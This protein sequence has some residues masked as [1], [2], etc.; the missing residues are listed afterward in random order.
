MKVLHYV[1]VYAPAWQFGGP[2]LSVSQLCEGLV[3][4]GH[5]VEIFTSN[6]GLEN[7]PEIIPNCPTVNNGVTVTY[8]SNVGGIGG[9]NSPQM[10][11]SV[12]ERVKEFD[13]VHITGIWQPTSYAACHAAKS[14]DIPYILSLRGAL[15]PYSWSQKT[16]KKAL[17]Y[18]WREHWN[19]NNA[20]AI[21]YTAQ[22]EFEECRWLNLPGKPIISPN[23]L[24]T[25]FWQPNPSGAKQWRREQGFKEDE[26]LLLNIGRLHHK[27]GLDLLPHVL[28]RIRDLEW[29]MIFVGGDD[30][31]T[32]DKLVGEFKYLNLLDRVRFL[33]KCE[34]KELCT[35]YSACNLFVLPSRHENFGNVVIE[36]LACGC[37]VMISDKVGVHR[38]IHQAGMGWVLK[39]NITNW[40]DQLRELIIND[41]F[42]KPVIVNSK[43]WVELNFSVNKTAQD[44]LLSY[45]DLIDSAS[46]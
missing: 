39:R 1:P 19:V 10:E 24:D 4:L 32:K 25:D 45:H 8:F 16:F 17:Y 46:K 3:S 33:P 7:N 28:E 38:E 30:D 44:M 21:H 20:T 35:I 23:G 12:K 27:K 41:H 36:S 31:G 29:K 42:L 9:I 22:Q 14:F 11:E 15:C 18:L 2:V 43:K 37:P 6:T 13:L 40:A 26:F 34:P 5:E